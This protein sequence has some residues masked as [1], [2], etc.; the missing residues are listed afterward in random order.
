MGARAV[1]DAEVLAALGS[2]WNVPVP[3]GRYHAKMYQRADRLR[4]KLRVVGEYLEEYRAGG[5]SVL[6][7]S[8][9]SGALLEILRCYGNE[10]F[11]TDVQ[12]FEFL[13]S[14]KIPYRRVD[15]RCLP[16]PFGDRTFDLVTCIGSIQTYRLPWRDVITDFC[17]VA[18][19][20]VLLIANSGDVF[21]ANKDD[22]IEWA[23]PGWEL[24][25]QYRTAFRWASR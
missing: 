18:R 9:G 19:R 16:Y 24:E 6:D 20:N 7:F 10:I 15:G 3:P 23:P 21:D 11:G 8:C 5:A 4:G 2:E 13:E 14:Q 25:L 12:Y 17:R 22:L 1:T